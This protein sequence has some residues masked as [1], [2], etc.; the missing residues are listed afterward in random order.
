MNLISLIFEYSMK[1][2]DNLKVF[3]LFVQVC[4]LVIDPLVYINLLKI[5]KNYQ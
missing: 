1:D 4:L 3:G 2:L 5:K